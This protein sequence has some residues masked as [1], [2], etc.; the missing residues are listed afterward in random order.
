[1]RR[2]DLTVNA[3]AQARRDGQLGETA[4]AEAAARLHL[5]LFEQALDASTYTTSGPYGNGDYFLRVTPDALP[6]NG[7]S[8]GIANGGGNNSGE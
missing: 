8:I 2:R 4:P 6:N 3:I 7:T 1:M 5:P